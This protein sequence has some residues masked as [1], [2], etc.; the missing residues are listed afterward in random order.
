MLVRGEA[1]IGKS[2]LLLETTGNAAAR[3]MQVLR[4]AGV[5]SETHMP[6]AGLHQVLLPVRADISKL[7]GPQRDALGAAFGLTDA[8][9]PDLFLIALATLN[10]LGEAAVRAPVLLVAEDAHWLDR[11]SSDVLAFVARRLESEPILLLAALR[12]GFPSPL[13]GAGLQELS[14]DRLDDTAATALLDAHVP[15]MA[16]MVRTR[17]LGEAAGNPLALVE[18]PITA[19]VQADTRLGKGAT[20][21]RW[22]PLTTVWNRPSPPACRGCRRPPG[23][24]CWWPRSTTARP[25]R[26]S[27]VPLR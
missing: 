7:P 4:T 27:S 5:E 17:L 18:L 2:A 23:P 22:L 6:F 15:A 24:C 11:S 14:L 10:L 20:P 8:R 1:G 12:D 9:A 19:D 26:R 21:P 16:S 25:C 13:D 3:G